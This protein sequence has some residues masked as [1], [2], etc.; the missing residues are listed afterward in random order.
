METG[1]SVLG[2]ILYALL[3]AGLAVV[4]V[5]GGLV[6]SFTEGNLQLT[7]LPSPTSSP[8]SLPLATQTQQPASTTPL[9]TSTPTNTL[10]A[11]PSTT[12]TATG[13]PSATQTG[14]PPPSGW[15]PITI[16]RGDTLNNLAQEYG[17]TPEELIEAN[18]LVISQLDPGI[19]LYVPVKIAPT[20]I[21]CGPPSGWVY[22]Y[23]VQPGDTLFSISRRTGVS[24]AQLKQANCLISD[25][26]RVGQRLF[27][28]EPIEPPAP[29]T[30]TPTSPPPTDPPAP[31]NTPEVVE[32]TPVPPD[33]T[34][35]IPPPSGTR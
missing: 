25:S 17:T 12:P 33:I 21:P 14:C 8:T 20:P 2:G 5:A 32:R 19:I 11:L 31:T 35:E 27:L 4:L 1:I 18:C 7:L 24:L 23:I 6:L 30:R 28:P 15:K 10:T 9:T 13:V 26:I 29:P 16:D 22:T 34:L 3:A